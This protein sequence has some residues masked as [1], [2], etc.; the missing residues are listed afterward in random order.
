M[1]QR[2]GVLVLAAL[3]VLVVG[4]LLYASQKPATRTGENSSPGITSGTDISEQAVSVYF[5]ALEDNGQ[6]GE[7]IGCGDSLVPV[8]RNVVRRDIESALTELLS[9][10]QQS[11]GQS[12]LYNALSQSDLYIDSIETTDGVARVRL[13]GQVQMGGACDSPRLQAQLQNTIAQFPQVHEVEIL[14]NGQTLEQ[15]TSQR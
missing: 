7:K 6:S 14:I 5:V 12:G 8:E 9:E 3:A 13:S 11:I 10:K 2:I 1:M 4:Y 15:I